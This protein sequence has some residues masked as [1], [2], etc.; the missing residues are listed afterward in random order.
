MKEL[1]R[2]SIDVSLF[3]QLTALVIGFIALTR[4]LL[5]ED[6]V[7]NSILWLET[8]VQL[9]EASFYTWY[10]GHI[11][12]AITDVTKYRYYDWMLTTPMMLFST[13]VFYEY[14]YKKEKEPKKPLT[15]TA[16][17][18]EYSGST[19]LILFAN[20]LMLIF[21]YLQE[22]GTIDIITS[23]IWGFL[24]F[25][26]A[27]Y[28]MYARFAWRTDTSST[29]FWVMFVLWGLYG[30]AALLENHAKNIAYNVLDIFSKNF[31]GVFLS[32]YIFRVSAI[33][34]G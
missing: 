11:S 15:I 18:T 6:A 1:L 7:L 28:E 8:V 27:F 19:I 29:L 23:T 17:L 16:F 31:Y 32:Y 5:P 25:G 20:F 21:G 4:P 12:E 33:A 3:A 10:R 30:I 14:V 34:S 9:I 13:I 22:L 26:V 2:Q 24:F